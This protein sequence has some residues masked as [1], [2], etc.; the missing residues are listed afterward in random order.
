MNDLTSSAFVPRLTVMV[1]YGGAPFLWL[2]DDEEQAGVGLSI[3][4]GHYQDESS[5]LSDGLW[6]RFAD[7]AIEFDRT[8]FYASDFNADEWDWPA[9]HA[10]GRDLTRCLKEEVGDAYHVIYEKSAED[11]DM[12]IDERVE[13]LADGRWIP[14]PP[15][16]TLQA[17]A[18]AGVQAFRNGR[19][20]C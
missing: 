12:L 16:R 8:Q 17:C 1:D 20:N 4:N 7:W 15:H 10:R 19:W 2:V 11:P 6:Q 3:A 14:W 18:R 9:F 5:P 13:I